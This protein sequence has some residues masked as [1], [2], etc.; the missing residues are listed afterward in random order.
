MDEK[1]RMSEKEMVLEKTKDAAAVGGDVVG[2]KLRSIC[3][4]VV[5]TD[6]LYGWDYPNG[7]L[8]VVVLA[9]S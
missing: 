3:T 7:A 2:D 8:S 9:D 1:K 4:H 5:V 6:L